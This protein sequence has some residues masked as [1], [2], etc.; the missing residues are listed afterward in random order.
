MQYLLKIL[1]IRL[2]KY[3]ILS[4]YFKYNS[5]G[6]I[7]NKMIKIIENIEYLQLKEA[8]SKIS[9]LMCFFNLF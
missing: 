1:P 2:R 6:S 4:I 8:L 3:C 9:F 5:Y 7:D